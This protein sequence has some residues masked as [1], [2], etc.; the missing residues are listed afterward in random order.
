MRFVWRV[1]RRGCD[2]SELGFILWLEGKGG[3][4]IALRSYRI[5]SWKERGIGRIWM[6]ASFTAPE[7]GGSFVICAEGKG[8]PGSIDTDGNHAFTAFTTPG[9]FVSTSVRCLYYTSTNRQRPSRP[10]HR[11]QPLAQPA[12][13]EPQGSHSLDDGLCPPP[14]SFPG[15]P[16]PLALPLPDQRSPT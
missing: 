11:L 5:F 9:N 2:E 16:P 6:E 4:A 8:T 3:C 13:R 14:P 10:R 12:Q 15:F 7:G 1:G